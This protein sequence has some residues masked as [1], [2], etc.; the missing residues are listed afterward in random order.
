MRAMPA[1]EL[2]IDVVHT[3]GDWTDLIRA[4]DITSAAEAIVVETGAEGE[5]AMALGD[6]AFVQGLNGQFR[7][8]DAPT[9]VLSFPSGTSGFLGDIALA[10]ETLLRE[11]EEQAKSP[12]DHAIHLIVHGILHLLGYDHD[13]DE[14]A[15]DMEALE[16]RVLG[17]LGI[18]NP[19][20]GEP[21]IPA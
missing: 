7:G 12:R 13:T 10:R 2:T 6:D 4:D 19:Y 8:K 21:G 3:G 1:P 14:Q 9:N 11:A 5:I 18:A 15:G 16:V 20:K 17:R